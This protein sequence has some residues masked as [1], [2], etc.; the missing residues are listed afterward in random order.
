MVLLRFAKAQLKHTTGKNSKGE[1]TGHQKY[2]MKL[3]RRYYGPFQILSTL[4]ETAYR[5]KLPTNWHIH[6]AFNVSLLK[7]F[8]GD[9]PKEIV[10]EEPPLFDEPEEVLQPKEILRHE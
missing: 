5:L 6:S 7:T 8:K 10:Q 2:Y 1:H 9:P 4:N 3:A